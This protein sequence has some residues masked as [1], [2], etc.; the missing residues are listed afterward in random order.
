MQSQDVVQK[1]LAVTKE[2]GLKYTK[3]RE[4]LIRFLADKNRY[5]SAREVHEYMN[6]LFPGLSYDTVYRNLHDFSE[7]G[8]FE[9]TDFNAEMK[10]RLHCSLMGADHHHHHFICKYCGK[11]KELKMCPMDFFEEQL[12]GCKIEG[13]RFEIYGMCEECSINQSMQTEN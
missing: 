2:N 9:E 8:I 4:A 13:H 7:L 11:T 1:A 10:F 3:K 5:V 6:E 12:A